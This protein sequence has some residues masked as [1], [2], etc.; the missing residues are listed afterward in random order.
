MSVSRIDETVGK[1][2]T[3]CFTLFTR[4]AHQVYCFL[5]VNVVEGDSV[6]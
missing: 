6:G 4:W 2:G 3:I 1:M 5:F